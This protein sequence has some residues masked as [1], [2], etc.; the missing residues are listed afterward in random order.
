MILTLMLV[1][2]IALCLLLAWGVFDRV[3][4]TS[5]DTLPDVR[6]CFVVL[7][8]VALFGL[9]AP[10]VL[11]F[12]PSAFSLA[13]TG[14]ICFVQAVTRRYWAKGVPDRFCKPGHAPRTRRSTDMEAAP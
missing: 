12:V 11:D 4:M 8:A 13:I 1:A 2:H 3:V 5:D 7:G 6:L 9:A 10:A 14:A